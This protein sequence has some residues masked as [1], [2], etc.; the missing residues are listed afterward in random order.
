MRNDR[1][2]K[3]SHVEESKSGVSTRD[4]RIRVK[5]DLIRDGRQHGASHSEKLLYQCCIVEGIFCAS[6]P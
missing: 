4:K 2:K 5:R 3:D 6:S 1:E